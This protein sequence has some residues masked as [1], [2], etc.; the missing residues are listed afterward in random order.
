MAKDDSYRAVMDRR[1]EIMKRAIGMDYKSFEISPLSFDYEALMSSTGYS[2]EDCIRIQRDAKVGNTPLL[3]LKNLTNAAR[4][5]AGGRRGARIFIKDEA[6]NPSGSFKDR[7]AAVSVHH[8]KKLGYK[9]VVAATSGNYGAAVASQAA[10]KNLRCIVLQECFDSKGVGQPEI[11]EKQRKCE[12][13][14]A[15]VIQLTVGPELF[16]T[17]LLILEETGYFNASLYSPFGIAG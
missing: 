2:L 9:G 17:F 5:V 11:L 1:N 13:L 4:L 14:G 16:H 8:A 7:R 12:S 3:E 6:S 10:M 15:E